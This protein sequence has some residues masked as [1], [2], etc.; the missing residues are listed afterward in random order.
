MKYQLTALP[1]GIKILTFPMPSRQ[2]ISIGVWVACGGRYENINKSGM[3]HFIEHMVFKGT[4]K[5]TALQIK[6]NIEGAG[7]YINAFTGE[8]C[9]C[10]FAKV[11]AKHLKKAV[12][13]LSEMVIS[14]NLTV[15]DFEKEK[16][17]I[18]EEIKLYLDLPMHCVEDELS[19]LM[20]PNQSL[21][22]F[23]AGTQETLKNIT[24][25]ELKD[26][27]AAHYTAQNICITAC[28]NIS[29]EALENE[30]KLNFESL[31][32]SQ[33]NHFEQIKGK[34]ASARSKVIEKNLE[35]THLAL[36]FPASGRKNENRFAEALLNTMLGANMSSRLFQ[37]VRERKSLAYEIGSHISH[38][39]ETGAL[40]IAAGIH[41][42]KRKESLD[43]I[44]NE[45]KKLKQKEP[46]KNELKRAKEFIGGQFHLSLENTTD[47]MLWLGEN[48]IA[49][50]KVEDEEDLLRK[51]NSITPAEIK[52]SACEIFKTDKINLTILG[53]SKKTD[54]QTIK[55]CLEI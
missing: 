8:E 5:Y 11:T 47:R 42:D 46:S 19:R 21:G 48:L 10:F 24:H 4:K 1:N 39:D 37:Q 3:S 22:M 34:Q 13:V 41:N 49:L 15:K 29:H 43:T 2:S 51:I 31:G 33:P 45:L 54:S 50:K 36:G 55:D 17:I 40:V 44:L 25:K 30:V 53:P 14:P 16:F 26:F 35:Q 18:S 20:W 32:K 52:K 7:G 23:L 27:K 12:S 28:G 38:Y 9:T 6:K